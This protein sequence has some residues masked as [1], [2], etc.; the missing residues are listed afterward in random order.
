[1]RNTCLPEDQIKKYPDHRMDHG[2]GLAN[3]KIITENIM[4]TCGVNISRIPLKP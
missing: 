1:M 2:Y 4:V 3:I